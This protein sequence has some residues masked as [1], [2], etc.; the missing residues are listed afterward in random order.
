MCFLRHLS[1][2]AAMATLEE[3]LAFKDKIH[4]V[5][6]ADFDHD[7]VQIND[8]VYRIKRPLLPFN[9]LLNDRIRDLGNQRRRR[10]GSVHFFEGA[11]DLAGGHALSVQKQDF[12]PRGQLLVHRGKS[13]LVLFD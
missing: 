11:H 2:E 6:L 12:V 9:H 3:A 13:T 5:G 4:A 7:A 1:A 8:R 10:I